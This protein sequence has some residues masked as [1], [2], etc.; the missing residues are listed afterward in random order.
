MNID[1]SE[2]TQLTAWDS[3]QAP[4]SY[5]HTS[6][7]PAW[8]P[9]GMRLAFGNPGTGGLSIIRTDGTGLVHLTVPKPAGWICAGCPEYSDAQP[10]WSPGGG[11][12][13]FNRWEDLEFST[14][15][16][17]NADGSNPGRFARIEGTV[18]YASWSGVW[19]PDGNSVA[20]VSVAAFTQDPRYT[21]P[22]SGIFVTSPDGRA[23]RRVDLVSSAFVKTIGGWSRDRDWLVMEILQDVRGNLVPDIFILHIPTGER[24][25]LTTDGT[26]R[27]PSVIGR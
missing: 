16:S 17:V 13:L 14:I 19:S 26:S 21:A 5:A 2:G 9:D 25:R 7:R 18:T 11:K 1:G 22:G 4:W 8:S 24:V 12:I 27:A 15:W 23:T 10:S 3:R 20:F 6:S